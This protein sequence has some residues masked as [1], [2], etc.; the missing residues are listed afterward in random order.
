MM[1]PCLGVAGKR[2]DRGRELSFDEVCE[3]DGL[4]DGAQ[5]GADRDPDLLQVLGRA[6]VLYGLWPLTSHVRQGPLDGPDDVSQGDL[7]RRQREPVATRC[8]PPGSDYP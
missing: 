8:T 1:H 3:G 4:E 7:L 6:R 5:V 2:G